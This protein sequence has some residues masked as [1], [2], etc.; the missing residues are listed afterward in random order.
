MGSK[1]GLFEPFF[2]GWYKYITS[3]Q[4]VDKHIQE[5]IMPSLIGVSVNGVAVAQ[6][7]RQDIVPFSR[8]GTRKVVWYKIG[9]E[10]TGAD[11]VINMQ[12]MNAIIDAIQTRMEIVMVG[13]PLIR[14]N[15]A[16]FMVAVFEDTA[17]DGM[18]INLADTPQLN[19]SNS[20]TLQEV[21]RAL[22]FGGSATVEKFYLAG[23]PADH[24]DGYDNG[25]STDNIYQEYDTKGQFDNNSYTDPLGL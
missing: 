1:L 10:N 17:N 22:P 3:S 7:Y 16:K 13:A 25:F 5:I 15:Y 8:F 11:N 2:V 9:H 4:S 19:N 18:N 23:A 24:Y 21:L 14:E 6:N 20:T 12:H